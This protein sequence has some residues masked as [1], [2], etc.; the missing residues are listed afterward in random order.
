MTGMTTFFL[1][2]TPE[3]QQQNWMAGGRFPNKFK[4][5]LVTSVC[6]NTFN[7]TVNKRI[8]MWLL[9]ILLSIF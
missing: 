9:I 2:Q 1:H 5:D 7:N 3:V 4:K 8:K 6:R